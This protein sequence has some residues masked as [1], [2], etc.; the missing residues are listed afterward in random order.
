[1]TGVGRSRLQAVSENASVTQLELFFDL[2]L[3]FAFTQV[4]DL[5]AH[6]TT[7]A[8]LL[9]AFLVLAVMWWVWIAYAWLGNVIKADEGIARVALFVAMGAALI[10]ALAIPEAFHDLPGGWYA[11]LVFA[12]G[13]LVIRIVHLIVFWLASTEDTQ[14]RGQV[15]RWAAGSITIGT[16]LLII[17]A[18]NS[19]TA[20]IWL[21]IAAIAGDMVWT[22]F[23]GNDWR[24]NSAGHFAERHGLIVIVA[25]G[26]SIVSIGVGVA[27]LPISWPIAVGA[28]L[29]LAV[30][31][32]LWWAYFD[33]G[34]TVVEHALQQAR[35]ERRVQIARNCYTYWHFPM[36]V[37]II[38]LS[39]GLKKVLNYLGGGADHT[40]HDRLQGIPLFALYGGV[41][42]YLI[43]LVG[44]RQ[45]ATGV[46]LW[47][48]VL[49]A[50][51]LVALIPVA[52]NLPAMA[53]LA[54]LCAVLLAL[55]V[56]E[57]V[58]YAE[59]REAIRHGEAH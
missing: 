55:I 6:E 57:V 32:L 43:A 11:P 27:G 54:L 7:A 10:M 40:L 34:A 36:V 21:W 28:L 33:V 30:S 39:L 48:R 18:L 59:P 45:Y 37:G 20:Q 42:L 56:W 41:V 53:A 15:T 19:G 13:Y 17:A 50:V 35:G 4:T 22:L 9:R 25:L 58:R 46:L 52:S 49:T 5:A 2:V 38:A 3:V 31:A 23:A 12:I 44:F 8:N 24:L 14:L 51:V 29:A 47:P 1:M 16:V 26:E